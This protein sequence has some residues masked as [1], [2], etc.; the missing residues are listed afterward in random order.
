MGCDWC[1]RLVCFDK[2]DFD[3]DDIFNRLLILRSPGVGPVGYQKLVKQFGAVAAAADAWIATG[4]TVNADGTAEALNADYAVITEADGVIAATYTIG[5]V[6]VIL[7][8]SMT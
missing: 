8:Q 1:G 5:A 6:T 4:L 7:Q 2:M 3:M